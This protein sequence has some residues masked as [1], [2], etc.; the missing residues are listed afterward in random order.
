M[1]VLI[2]GGKSLIAKCVADNFAKNKHN[3]LFAGRII[4]EPEKLA[5]DFEVRYQ[6]KA[7]SVIFDALDYNSH[8]KF[9]EDVLKEIPDLDYVLIA[10]GYLGEQEKSQN[11]W[12]EA[13]LI[14]ESNFVGVVS[15]ANLFANHFEQKKSG[16][17]IMI[18]SVAG[19]RGRPSNYTYGSAKA[20][21]TAYASGLRARLCKSG[22]NVL[23]VK[24]GF[25]A[26][27]MT[28]GMP[29]PKLLTASPE[30]VGKEIYKAAVKRKS[31]LYTPFYWKWIMR[32]VKLVPEG[33]FK[34]M[35][36]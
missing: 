12:N 30:K 16:N 7:S 6:V 13:K 9:V 29:L 25:V 2:L 19:D 35:K 34:K 3:V 26:T 21:L 18:S 24:P 20:G 14:I 32:V 10:F 1:S 33:I 5:K 11:E 4:D 31:V 23:T 27:P 8:P 22:V 17:I 28:Y 15:I 36:T